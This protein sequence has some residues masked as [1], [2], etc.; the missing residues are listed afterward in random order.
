MTVRFLGASLAALAL[1]ASFALGRAT[2]PHAV[3]T[4]QVPPVLPHFMCYKTQF[5][6]A[7][8]AT[9]LVT[10]QFGA[11]KRQFYRADMFCAPAKKQPISFKPMKVPGNPDHIMCYRTEG[12]AVNASRKIAN[13]LEQTYFKGLQPSYFCMPTYKSPG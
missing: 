1:I 11:A 3:A 8:V 12:A 13:Q 2:G 10:D 9:A 4:A 7:A 5:G 6:T